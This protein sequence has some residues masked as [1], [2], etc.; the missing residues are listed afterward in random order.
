MRGM[1]IGNCVTYKNNWENV[2]IFFVW[3]TNL[4]HLDD[5]VWVVGSVQTA[6]NGSHINIWLLYLSQW[7]V[8]VRNYAKRKQLP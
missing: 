1:Y 3:L 6:F 7:T 2:R 5:T 4:V 8:K